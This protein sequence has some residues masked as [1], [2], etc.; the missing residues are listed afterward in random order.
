MRKILALLLR[1]LDLLQRRKESDDK[2]LMKL[3]ELRRLLRETFP[4]QYDERGEILSDKEATAN[5]KEYVR[6]LEE[7][8][9]RNIYGSY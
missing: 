3:D 1:E 7:Q 4:H 9:E 6:L 2:F 5:Y 8:A